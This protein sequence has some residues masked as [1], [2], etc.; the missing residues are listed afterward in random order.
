MVILIVLILLGMAI[1]TQNPSLARYV[2]VGC[3]V[4]G[5]L[6]LISGGSSRSRYFNP[7]HG[8]P[9]VPMLQFNCPKGHGAFREVLSKKKI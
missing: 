3:V 2:V 9:Q 7:F 1:V 8:S 5:A 6:A 4:L